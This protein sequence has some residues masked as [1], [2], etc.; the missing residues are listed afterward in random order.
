MTKPSDITALRVL[1]DAII[2]ETARNPD[3]AARVAQA[4][5]GFATRSNA[6]TPN[7]PAGVEGG[8]DP[9]LLDC[10]AIYAAEGAAALAR[11]LRALTKRQLREIAAADPRVSARGLGALSAPEIVYRIV[12]AYETPKDQIGRDFA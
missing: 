8:A 10:A 2:E 11:R 5:S 6:N 7:A 12:S 9:P 1:F 3:F 4:L